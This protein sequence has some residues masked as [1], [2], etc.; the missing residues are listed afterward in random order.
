[1]I[2]PDRN[3]MKRFH[4]KNGI[5]SEAFKLPVLTVVREWIDEGKKEGFREGRIELLLAQLKRILG[6]VN[7]DLEERVNRL[8]DKEIEKL[9]LDLL[10]IKQLSDLEEWFRLHQKK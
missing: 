10:G 6:R 7:S 8:N 2:R 4:S 5:L 3:S 1:M 9:S